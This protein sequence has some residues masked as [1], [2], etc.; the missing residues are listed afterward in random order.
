MPNNNTQNAPLPS[1]LIEDLLTGIEA[2]TPT[3]D[4]ESGVFRRLAK[5]ALNAL[6][7]DRAKSLLTNDM[8]FLEL[9]IDPTEDDLTFSESEAAATAFNAILEHKG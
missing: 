4:V 6:P 7:A 8:D 2:S 3:L 5:L 9:D 1:E